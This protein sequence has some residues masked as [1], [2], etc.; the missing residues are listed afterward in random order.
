MAT[1][2]AFDLDTPLATGSDDGYGYGMTGYGFYLLPFNA[3]VF[4]LPELK[5]IDAYQSTN[6]SV[7]VFMRSKDTG[8]GFGF[9]SGVSSVVCKLCKNGDGSY[10][11]ITPTVTHVGGGML[12]IALTGTHLNTLGIATLRVEHFA[13]FTNDE[14]AI[15]VLAVNQYDKY[16]GRFPSGAIVTDGSNTATTF[17][18]D[19]VQ[20]TLDYWKDAYITFRTGNLAGQVKKITGFNGTTKF[21]TI[22]NALTATPTGG[23]L[24]DIVNT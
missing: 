17:K 5:M 7:R 4:P 13:C 10:S 20:V 2:P 3:D 1:I 8:L 19:L 14:S 12:N 22:A 11:T 15:N 6:L 23:D 9:S 18:T 21:I 16:H 24:F